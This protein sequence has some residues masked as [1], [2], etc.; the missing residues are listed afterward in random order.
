MNPIIDYCAEGVESEHDVEEIENNVKN[1]LLG[2]NATG[3]YEGCQTAI[4]IS[5]LTHKGAL[6]VLSNR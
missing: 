6:L 4:K 5:A 2:L 1:I 3:Q